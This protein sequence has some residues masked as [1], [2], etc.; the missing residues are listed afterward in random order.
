M[1]ILGNIIWL[2][3][4]GLHTAIEY[5]IAGLVLLRPA[6][7]HHHH[8]HPLGQ[9]AFPFGKA[10]PITIRNGSRIALMIWAL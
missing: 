10:G 1:K 6:T 7:L 5:F 9:D 2:I 4:G 3:F 8:R